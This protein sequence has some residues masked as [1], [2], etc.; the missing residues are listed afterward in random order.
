[1][2][3]T[4]WRF[5]FCSEKCSCATN[6]KNLPRQATKNK[7]TNNNSNVTQNILRK[8][9]VKHALI[10]MLALCLNVFDLLFELTTT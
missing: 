10:I 7:A 2:F 1:L 4:L 9:R 6:T 5:T 8:C 3:L